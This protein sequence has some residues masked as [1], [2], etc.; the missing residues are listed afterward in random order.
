MNPKIIKLYYNK[1]DK[2]VNINDIILHPFLNDNKIIWEY[3]NPNDVS[4][5][6]DMIEGH[7]QELL[8][9]FLSSIGI[10]R[11]DWKLLNQNYCSIASSDVYVNKELRN[12]INN[13]TDNLNGIVLYDEEDSLNADVFVKGWSIE[14]PE[15]DMLY[16]HLDL[17]LSNPSI[18]N[19]PINDDTLQDFI[20]SFI[21][22]DDVLEQES[23]YIWEIQ[24]LLFK[25]KNLFDEHY[26]Y[27]NAV[28]GYYDTFGNGLT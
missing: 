10:Q 20:Q 24:K 19:K 26:M 15:N 12:K 5:S 22:S 4:F 25:E 2:P 18:N 8:H 27:I 28:I 21:Y 9:D 1:L 16:F 3:E 23:D 7:L 17:E 6:T 11:N 13:I 14:Y